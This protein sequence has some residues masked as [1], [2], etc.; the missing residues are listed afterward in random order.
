MNQLLAG[1]RVLKIYAWESA[2]EALVRPSLLL[3][4][5]SYQRFSPL[6]C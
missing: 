3:L 1:I 5:A 4:P 2:Q 6:T